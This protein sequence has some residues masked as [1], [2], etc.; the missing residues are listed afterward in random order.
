MPATRPALVD[1]EVMRLK[2]RRD[3]E[4]AKSELDVVALQIESA[5]KVCEHTQAE[6]DRIYGAEV[7]AA[8]QR[9][10][11]AHRDAE[12]VR[13]ATVEALTRRRD[14]LQGAVDAMSRALDGNTDA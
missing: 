13:N 8:D 3:I 7:N 6:A 9:R 14:D 11:G 5:G 2:W 12:K 1:S 4:N 10:Q